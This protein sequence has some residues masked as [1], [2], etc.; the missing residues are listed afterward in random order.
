MSALLTRVHA[1]DLRPR[2]LRPHPGQ[3]CVL[4]FLPLE[5]E[6]EGVLTPPQS[7]HA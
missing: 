5:E 1:P 4:T 7:T 3:P 2:R 6:G